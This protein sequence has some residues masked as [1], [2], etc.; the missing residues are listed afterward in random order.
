MNAPINSSSN[1][2]QTARLG[3]LILQNRIVMAPLTRS[4]AIGNIP[5]SWMAEYYSQR[6]DA[7]LIVTEATSP[8]PNG[9]GYPRIPGIFNKAQAEGWKLVTDAVHRR[10][11]KIFLQIMHTGRVGTTANLPEN[12]EVIAPS[13]IGLTGEMWTDAKGMQPYSIPREMNEVDIRNAIEEFV[14]G[15]K[16]AMEAGFDGIELHGANG[17]LI[18]QFLNPNSN[19]RDDSYG[20]SIENRNRFAVEVAEQV[21]SAIGNERTSIRLSPYGVFNEMSPFYDGVEEQYEL[22]AKEFN[23]IGLAYIHLVDHSSM[24][25]PEVSE[26]TV[27][28]IRKE[29]KNILIF[30]GGYDKTRAQSDLQNHKCDLIAFGRPFIANPDLVRRLKIDAPLAQPDESTFYTPGEKGYSDYPTWKE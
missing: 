9:L 30:S 14:Q 27:Q 18:E 24:G 10:N 19:R 4:R 29:F 8:S 5:N 15:A 12:A 17:Y 1:L 16:N 11:G 6:A 23:R 26:T 21:A 20:G 25:A 28:T 7:G 13:S 3:K 22:L 2:F